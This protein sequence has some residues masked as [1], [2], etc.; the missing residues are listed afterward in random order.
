MTIIAVAFD[1]DD[2]LFLERDYVRSAFEAVDE[3]G[4]ANV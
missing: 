2:T 3:I 4:R 1:L